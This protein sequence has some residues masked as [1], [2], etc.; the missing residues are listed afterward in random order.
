M[1]EFRAALMKAYRGRCAISGC[2][3]SHVLQAAHIDPVA[4]GGRDDIGNGLL[5]RADLHNLFDKHSSGSTSANSTYPRQQH[6]QWTR[7]SWRRADARPAR[8]SQRLAT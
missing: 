5:P 4:R 6:D 8:V 7:G 2:D 3:V 1:P